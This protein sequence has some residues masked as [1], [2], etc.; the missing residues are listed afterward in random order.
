MGAFE[1]RA[2]KATTAQ[3]TTS[4]IS[5]SNVFHHNRPPCAAPRHSFRD[6][7]SCQVASSDEMA[8]HLVRDVVERSDG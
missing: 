6:T 5:G 7:L 2:I 3:V 8:I 4:P 1:R